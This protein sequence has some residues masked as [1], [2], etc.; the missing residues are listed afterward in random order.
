MQDLHGKVAVVTGGASGIG[1]AIAQRLA[2]DGMR[3][4]LAD[5][6]RAAL[7]E[8]AEELRAEGTQILEVVVD[9]RDAEQVQL[10]AERTVER[11]GAIHVACNNAG[12]GS[13]PGP[14]WSVPDA[15]WQWVLGVNF[16][17]VLHGIRA[18]VP[19]ML[20]Q[21]EGHVVNTG[22]IAGLMPGG[23]PTGP[24]S[25]SKHAVVA[26]SEALFF[27]LQDADAPIGV[28][29]LC[30]AWVRTRIMESGRNR[31]ADLAPPTPPDPVAE[32]VRDAMQQLVAAGMDPAQV[33]DKVRT[34]ILENRFYVLPHNDDAW[35]API[36]NRMESIL[37]QR[38]P[39]RTPTPGAE[40]MLAAITET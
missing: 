31:P 14:V 24:Y 27:N 30:P 23:S 1:R 26:L 32:Q 28:S 25:V 13:G 39:T 37:A 35:L 5:V 36:R 12:V 40:L 15:D 4:V 16:W 8:T 10:L 21:G 22:S 20:E 18:F 9:V 19:R 2:A 34:A 6:E 17:G 29:V 11:F 3:I 38:D 7:A 33:A